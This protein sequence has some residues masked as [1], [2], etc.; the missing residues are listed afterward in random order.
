MTRSAVVALLVGGVQAAS[1]SAPSRGASRATE[2]AVTV[3][4]VR[5]QI[6]E[7][8]DPSERARGTVLCVAIDPG[9]A[10]QS[11]GR[12]VM[13]RLAD[14][15]SLRRAAECDARPKGAVEAMTLRPAIIVTAGPMQWISADE[16]WVTVRYFRSAQ[17]SAIRKYRVV[18]EREGWVSLGPILLDGP[19]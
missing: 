9:G 10:P 2:S 8:L 5:Q 1:P 4:V 11:P 7:H 6:Q 12:E 15:P 14:E 19:A 18:L 13:A 16:V 17:L 3:A